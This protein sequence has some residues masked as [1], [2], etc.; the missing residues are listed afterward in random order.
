MALYQ[1]AI[2]SHPNLA[3]YYEN[4]GDVLAHVGKWKEAATLY[5]KAIEIKSTSAL[6]DHNLGKS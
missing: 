6:S 3:L 5:Q 2:E 1:K 4:L